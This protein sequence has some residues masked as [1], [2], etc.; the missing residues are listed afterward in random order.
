MAMTE[1]ESILRR[2]C[3]KREWC[4]CGISGPC[5]GLVER[6]PTRELGLAQWL[7]QLGRL[8]V[9]RKDTE[10]SGSGVFDGASS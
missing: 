1:T 2:L 3:L 9:T 4:A 7:G 5:I 6:E 10:L 8:G